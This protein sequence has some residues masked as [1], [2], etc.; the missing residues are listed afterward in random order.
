MVPRLIRTPRE[1]TKAVR[2]LHTNMT[3]GTLELIEARE[4]GSDGQFLDFRENGS[5]REFL[6][7]RLKCRA[8]QQSFDQSLCGD[9]SKWARRVDVPN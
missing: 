8:C 7:Y 9:L 4:V 3:N 1:L 6:R 2:V 5:W